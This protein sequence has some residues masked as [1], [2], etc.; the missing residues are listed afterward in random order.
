MSTS[1]RDNCMLVAVPRLLRAQFAP[2]ALAKIRIERPLLSD[3][4]DATLW[5]S[6]LTQPRGGEPPCWACPG[7]HP[8]GPSSHPPSPPSLLPGTPLT[9]TP[10]S[11]KLPTGDQGVSPP[12]P[13]ANGLH[14]IS[15]SLCRADETSFLG[16]SEHFAHPPHTP[17][18]PLGALLYALFLVS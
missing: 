2:D 3:Y 1:P 12:V 9:H 8:P 16:E 17:T 5:I 13:L 18:R 6:V 10:F 4:I 15:N 14:W 11:L 7:P